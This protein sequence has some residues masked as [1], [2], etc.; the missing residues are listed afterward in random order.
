MNTHIPQSRSAESIAAENSR[1]M[2]G[3]YKWMTIGLAITGF[4]AYSL[5]QNEQLVIQI[6]T[7]K[8]L[9]LKTKAVEL[10][11]TLKFAILSAAS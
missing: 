5:G 4:I 7:N 8:I 11:V 2:T 9:L 1:F 3:V 6:V 10:K